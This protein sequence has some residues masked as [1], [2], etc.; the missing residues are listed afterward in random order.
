MK[1][2]DIW[3]YTDYKP[4]IKAVFA[5]M[6]SGGR[7]QLKKLAEYL[8]VHSTLVSQVISG[9]KDFSD[10]QSIKVAEFLQLRE[11]ETDYF[12]HLVFYSK[13]GSA[14][15]QKYHLS[16][17]KK[18][19]ESGQSVAH[20]IGKSSELSENDKIRYY[21][22]WR[23]VAVWLATSI[24]EFGNSQGISEALEIPKN[25]VQDILDFLLAKGLCKKSDKGFAMDLQRIH[26]PANSPL[27]VNHHL[28]W[29]MKSLAFVQNAKKQELAF[30]S[31]LSISRRDFEKVRGMILKLIED[32]SE[33]VDKTDP[34]II[35]CLNIDHFMI[36]K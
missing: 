31:P 18:L 28:N 35:A 8:G 23:Y 10:E 17:I 3:S 34:E 20:H 7:G 21:S 33:V 13:A 14:D 1:S 15:L 11:L 32:I 26:V 4:Y 12:L 24:E 36:T 19:K 9:D 16:K 29:R 22:D 30:T 6:S 27:V 2:A 5:S 25:N